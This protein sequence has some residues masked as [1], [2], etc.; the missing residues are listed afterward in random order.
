[1]CTCPLA[2]RHCI[3]TRCQAP[4]RSRVPA[5]QLTWLSTRHTPEPLAPTGRRAPQRSQERSL[6]VGQPIDNGRVYRASDALS[7]ACAVAS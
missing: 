1:V 7:R 6:G 2:D 4:H 3:L 5:G